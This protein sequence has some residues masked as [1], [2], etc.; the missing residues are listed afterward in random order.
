ML[1]GD[2]MLHTNATPT[3]TVGPNITIEHVVL[4]LRGPASS[5]RT[6]RWDGPTLGSGCHGDGLS[7]CPLTSDSTTLRCS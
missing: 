2:G 6:H 1:D 5:R 7:G 3:A 4:C